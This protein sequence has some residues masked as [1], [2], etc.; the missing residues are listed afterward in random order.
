MHVLWVLLLACALSLVAVGCLGLYYTA[1]GVW[2]LVLV[3]GSAGVAMV[4]LI[5]TA[6]RKG[7]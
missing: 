7:V 3:L 5:C 4:A 6:L 2:L 1:H